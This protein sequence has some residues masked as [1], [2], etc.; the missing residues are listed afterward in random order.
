MTT[1]RQK[2]CL[3]AAGRAFLGLGVSEAARPTSSVP[4]KEKAAET[5]TYGISC[6]ASRKKVAEHTVQ[7]PLKPF[8]NAPGS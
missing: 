1:T 7:T 4:A 5:N 6:F 2:V 3:T 8:A